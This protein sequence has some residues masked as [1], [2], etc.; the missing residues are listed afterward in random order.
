[1][2]VRKLVVLKNRQILNTGKFTHDFA[3]EVPDFEEVKG[4]AQKNLKKYS[5]EALVAT[6]RVYILSTNLLKNKYKIAKE[7][8]QKIKRG[9]KANLIVEPKE[10]NKFLKMM[11]D[12][13]RK[14]KKIKK[15]IK[16]EE[17]LK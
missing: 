5:Y 4:A 3:I 7:R 13:K 12:Y 10:E 16:Q 17:G 2:I 1:M 11:S 6:L 14:I 9:G 15:K 8:I